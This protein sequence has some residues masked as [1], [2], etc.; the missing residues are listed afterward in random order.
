M[1]SRSNP[2]LPIPLALPRSAIPVYYF[3]RK[4]RHADC[5]V[6]GP[7]GVRRA[8]SHPFS[9][10]CDNRLT[11]IDADCSLPRLHVEATANDDAELVEFGCLP[12]LAPTTRANHPRHAD[13]LRGRVNS[14]DEFLDDFGRV[15]GGFD[16]FWLLNDSDH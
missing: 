4:C 6:F 12:R 15:A 2:L 8:V 3:R 5:D 11:G 9:L 10:S 7:A 14:S 13:D 16:A 1:A